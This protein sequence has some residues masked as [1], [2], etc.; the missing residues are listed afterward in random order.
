MK[1]LVKKSNTTMQTREVK[2]T[3]EPK[4]ELDRKTS[5]WLEEYKDFFTNRMH[6]VTEAF[7]ERISCELLEWAHNN[8]DAIRVEQFFLK[9]NIP[10][11]TVGRWVDT[12]PN[13]K[14]AYD[15]ADL[16]IAFRREEG[17][18]RKG[19][20]AQIVSKTMGMFD[21]RYKAFLEWESRLKSQE[22]ASI[23]TQVVFNQIADKIPNQE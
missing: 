4:R 1:K 8:P 3:A 13:L 14:E 23:P 2:K 21:P 12:Y 9:K 16:V 7:L 22:N 10:L 15:S 6:P 17:A 11:R 5:P 18:M 20:N 19:W